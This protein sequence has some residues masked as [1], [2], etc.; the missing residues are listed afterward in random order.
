MENRK[1]YHITI[2]FWCN[3]PDKVDINTD[4][5]NVFMNTKVEYNQEKDPIPT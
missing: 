5:D 1:R 2:D 4:E 3:D